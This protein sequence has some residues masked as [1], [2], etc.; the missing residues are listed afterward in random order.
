[1][2][3]NKNNQQLP[4][5]LLRI[6]CAGENELI[7]SCVKENVERIHQ[8]EIKLSEHINIVKK[9]DINKY[10]LLYKDINGLLNLIKLQIVNKILSIQNNKN[11]EQKENNKNN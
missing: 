9:Q 1:S 4:T 2:N 8:L 5:I 3:T 6:L 11:N 7:I 10:E